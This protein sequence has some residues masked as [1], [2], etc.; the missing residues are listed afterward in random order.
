MRIAIYAFDGITMFH[1]AAPLMVFGELRRLGLA[2]DWHTELW[3]DAPGTIRTVEGYPIGDIADPRALDG[4]D[5]VV[6]PSWPVSL[7]RI[8]DEFRHLL[9]AAHA[10]GATVVGL[11]L[12]AFAVADS[13]LL[14]GRAA[15]THWESMPEL[16]LRQPSSTQDASVLFIDHGDVMT[17]AGTASAIDACLHLVRRHLGAAT[18]TRVARGLVVAPHRDGGQAQYIERPLPR[19]A[20][21]TTMAQVQQWAL[22]HL[23]ETLT[24]DALARRAN[25]SRRSFIRQFQTA[26]GATPARWVMA[27]RLDESRVLLETTDWGI[28]DIA[29]ASGFRSAV[30]FRQNFVSAYSTSPTTYRRQFAGKGA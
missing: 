13:G 9:R 19:D 8:D 4:A 16:A 29:A 18:A 17:S 2:D 15:V 23:R 10:S 21:D 1:L 28:D 30:T 27:Q 14:N 5:I 25:M 20:T 6:V 7:P 12:G 11:C 24:V 26:T 3:S 22:D